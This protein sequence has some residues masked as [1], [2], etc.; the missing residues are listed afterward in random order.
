MHM[1][2]S[3]GSYL[4]VVPHTRLLLQPENTDCLR[5]PIRWLLPAASCQLELFD[6]KRHNSAVVAAAADK[7]VSGQYYM[8]VVN[9]YCPALLDYV[10]LSFASVGTGLSTW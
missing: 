3:A 10:S 2:A 7:L 8:H 5:L 9:G 6:Q 4:L 1:H